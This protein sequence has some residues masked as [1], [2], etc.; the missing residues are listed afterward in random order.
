MQK[1]VFILGA[2]A[3]KNSGVPLLNEFIDCGLEVR[4]SPEIGR[5]R[6]HFDRIDKAL[7][8]LNTS[9]FAKSNINLKNIEDVFGMVEMGLLINKFPGCESLNEIEELRKSIIRFIVVTIEQTNRYKHNQGA[10]LASPGDYEKFVQILIG[11]LLKLSRSV[12]II[13]FNYDVALD[14]SLYQSKVDYDYSLSESEKLPALRL[15]KLHGSIN[16]GSCPKCNSI[17]PIS[18]REYF[19]SHKVTLNEENKYPETLP[20]L[21]GSTLDSRYHLGNCQTQLNDVPVLVPPTWNKSE[22]HQYLS[23]VWNRAAIDLG[24][25]ENIYIIGYSMPESDLFFRYIYA[26]GTINPRRRLKRLWNFNP[27]GLVHT[28]F[29]KIKGMGIEDYRPSTTRFHEA[30]DEI[31]R[32]YNLVK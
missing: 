31:G 4:I 25:A 16:W 21:I 17:V 2:G 29:E 20:I 10:L 7:T 27:E 14:L 9:I 24:E 19:Q 1:D 22:H 28:R 11:P 13:T 23:K 18:W 6:V 5:D 3:S 8:A 12:S 32:A 26:L 30:I 15:L